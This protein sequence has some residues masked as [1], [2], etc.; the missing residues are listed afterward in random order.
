[1]NKKNE[2]RKLIFSIPFFCMPRVKLT[3]RRREILD[4]QVKGF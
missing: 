3:R 4:E 1:M 2:G